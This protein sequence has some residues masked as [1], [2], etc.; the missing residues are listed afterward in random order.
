MP[1]SRCGGRCVMM[2]GYFKGTLSGCILSWT[3]SNHLWQKQPKQVNAFVETFFSV[4]VFSL[5]NLTS[6]SGDAKGNMKLFGQ[7]SPLL[8]VGALGGFLFISMEVV[9]KLDADLDVCSVLESFPPL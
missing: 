7:P 6:D 2:W 4:F 9:L 3:L 8:N 1:I 5:C